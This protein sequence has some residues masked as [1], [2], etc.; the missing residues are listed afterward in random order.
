MKKALIG[1]AAVVAVLIA[2]YAWFAW[3]RSSDRGQPQASAV[4]QKGDLEDTVSATGTLQP[5]D[6]V[7]VGT[8]VSGQ[9]K[10]L[11]VEIGDRVEKGQLLAEIDSTVYLTRVEATQ[12]QLKNQQAQLAERQ[13]NLRLAEQK[14]QRQANMMREQATTAEAVQVAQAELAAAK[15]Q[16]NSLRAQIQQTESTLRGDRANLEYTKIYAPMAGTVVTQA[17]KEGQTLN[18]NQ[19]APIVLRIA[20]LSSMT[21]QTQVS[22]ADVSRLRVGMPVYFTTLGDQ[23]KRWHGKLRQ[24]NPT[25]EVLNNVVLYNAL[26]DVP[27]ADGTL[28]TQMTAQVFF[29]VA[30]AKDVVLAPLS[31]LQRVAN[32]VFV[33]VLHE[34]GTVEER[35]VQ[36]GTRNRIMAQIVSGLQPGERLAT[37]ERAPPGARAASASRM[38]K[39][40]PRL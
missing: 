20:D 2:T 7:D 19:S 14:A 33:K 1:I 24:V 23:R 40:G 21:V 28:M 11:H 37:S 38:P 27:N 34:D 30:E 18:A 6:Y 36:V 12:A 31:A 35:K 26:F 8:Q 16:I 32:G 5:R 22:E 25:P 15:A 3:A 29:V 9:I 13:A 17:A 10:K 39:M 4:V